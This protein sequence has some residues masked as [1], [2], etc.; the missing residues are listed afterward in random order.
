[1]SKKSHCSWNINNPLNVHYSMAYRKRESNVQ[2][3]YRPR[4]AEET[5]Q[6][7]RMWQQEKMVVNLQISFAILTIILQQSPTY[8]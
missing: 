8:C 4:Y 6:L 1:M 2:I 7:P 5:L 3:N